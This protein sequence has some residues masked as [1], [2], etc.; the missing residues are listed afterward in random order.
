M[1]RVGK[2]RMLNDLTI[3]AFIIK[4]WNAFTTEQPLTVLRWNMGK[5]FP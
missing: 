2:S 3:A 4:A 1:D 5:H